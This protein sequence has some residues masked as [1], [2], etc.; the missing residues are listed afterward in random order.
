MIERETHPPRQ[1]MKYS[2]EDFPRWLKLVEKHALRDLKLGISAREILS[3]VFKDLWRFEKS[4]RKRPIPPRGPTEGGT[5]AELPTTHF[6]TK[7][8]NKKPKRFYAQ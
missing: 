3:Q 2:Y 5:G 1:K 6:K 7:T 4:T 8:K